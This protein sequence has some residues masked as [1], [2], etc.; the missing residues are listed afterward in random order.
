MRLP[1]L[2]DLLIHPF[3]HRPGV[4]PTHPLF[5]M[6]ILIQ[7]LFLADLHEK[8]L[9]YNR[10]VHEGQV[11]VGTLVSHQ[12][13]RVGVAA[14]VQ[15]EDRDDADDFVGVSL[16]RGG[17]LFRVEAY[18]PGGLAEVGALAWKGGLVLWV[19]VWVGDCVAGT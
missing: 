3:H 4:Q 15:V 17:E 19:F 1:P 7:P 10:P 11:R 9:S 8:S 14:E 2:G 18:E 16:Y 5:V 13:L 6:L 12:V